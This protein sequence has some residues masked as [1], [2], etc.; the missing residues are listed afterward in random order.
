LLQRANIPEAAREAGWLGYAP[1]SEAQITAAE[2]RLQRKLPPSLRSFYG[3]TNGWMLAG[4][5]IFDILPVDQI[6]WLSHS[7]PQLFDLLASDLDN[8]PNPDTPP[9]PDTDLD[10]EFWYE[11]GVRVRRCLVLNRRGDDA[12]WMLDPE[13]RTVGGEWPGGRFRPGSPA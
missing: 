11:Q 4:N 8:R 6:D 7:H 3:V 9:G 5:S 13:T 12:L 2:D 10:D 1:A